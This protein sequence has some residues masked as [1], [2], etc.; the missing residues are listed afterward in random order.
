MFQRFITCLTLSRQ[1]SRI[2]EAESLNFT[3][4]NLVQQFETYEITEILLLHY[5]KISN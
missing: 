4:S 3:L 1:A 5:T 2:E